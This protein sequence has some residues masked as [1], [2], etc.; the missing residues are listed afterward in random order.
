MPT[1]ADVV[2]ALGSTG[3][4]VHPE[5][6]REEKHAKKIASAIVQARASTPIIKSSLPALLQVPLLIL[7]SREKKTYI[8]ICVYV[9]VCINPLKSQRDLSVLEIMQGRILPYILLKVPAFLVLCLQ[10]PLSHK[11]FLKYTVV[12]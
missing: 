1:A 12:C 7:N 6:I 11:Q 8:H 2:N 10:H 4:C 5:S 9:C 3:T